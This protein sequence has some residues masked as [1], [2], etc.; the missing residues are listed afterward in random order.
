ML[1]SI[2]RCKTCD[3][4]ERA[5]GWYEMGGFGMT[6]TTKRTDEGWLVWFGGRRTPIAVDA[7]SRESAI[8]AARKKKM[9][10]GTNVVSA[11]KAN[12]SEKKTAANGGWIRTGPNGEPPGKSKLRG[13][14]PAPK[15]RRDSLNTNLD[16]KNI[17]INPELWAQAIAEAKKRFNQYPSAYANL[18]AANWYSKR[19]GEW[20]K[21]DLREWLSEK[22]MRISGTGKIEGECGMGG[23]GKAKCLS[24]AKARSMS[25]KERIAAV[26]RKRREDPNPDRKGKAINVSTNPKTK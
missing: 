9:R 2:L 15:G 13:Y 23:R 21:D 1:R 20:K 24:E 5:I 4:N 25:L 18:W 8:T 10:G 19:N 12:A 26:R 14:G 7:D 11:R 22:W 6:I 3:A 16:S 17:P